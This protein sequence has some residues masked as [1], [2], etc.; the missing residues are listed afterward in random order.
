MLV[1]EVGYIT[2]DE[3]FVFGASTHAPLMSDVTFM[4]KERRV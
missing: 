1:I 3:C 4:N 2:E